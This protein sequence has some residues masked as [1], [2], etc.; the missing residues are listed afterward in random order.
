MTL[1]LEHD[2]H[3]HVQDH[4]NELTARVTLVV[5]LSSLFTGLWLTQIDSIL[6]FVLQFLN[7]CV[8]GCLNLYDPARWSAV[9]WMSS[10]L[11]GI[12]TALPIFLQQ[13]WKFIHPGLLPTE[14]RWVKSW[15]LGS[16][17][18]L[19]LSVL[20]TVVLIFPIAF[21]IGH[22]THESVQ[23]DAR[24]DA[25]QMLTLI[26]AVIWTEII[27]ACAL[28]AMVLA[29]V[30]GLLN[31]D[32]ADWWRIRVYGLVV[33]LLLASLPNEGGL[34]VLLTILSILI[35]ERGARKWIQSEPPLFKGKKPLMDHEGGI[36]KILLIN[37]SID[38]KR[39]LFHPAVKLPIAN[40]STKALDISTSEQEQ[41]LEIILH[42]RLTDIFIDGLPFN[43][44]PKTFRE[45]CRSL[46]CSIWI[47]QNFEG[48]TQ[49]TM[50]SLN[51]ELR[52]FILLKIS[53]DVTNR[54]NQRVQI[55]FDASM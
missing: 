24:Y 44:L 36:R 14:R 19:L 45:N 21:D 50:F 47:N 9:R 5:F 34:T 51:D 15:L 4:L 13:G 52:D 12:G 26:I 48:E 40:T 35:I 20:A 22:Q 23:L 7:P 17:V 8:E 31:K 2:Q 54:E 28:S 11:L 41:I 6:D 16:S 37:H 25:I 30:V 43:T 39:Q 38:G 18:T 10:A 29:G 32:T 1:N 46:G 49:T 33:L 27:V 3:S 42:N 53:K 55:I